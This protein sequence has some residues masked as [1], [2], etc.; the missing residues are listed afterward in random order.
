MP[1]LAKAYI[2]LVLSAGTIVLLYAASTWSPANL[3]QFTI[4]LGLAAL[5]SVLKVR[6]PRLESTISP[7][8]VFLLSGIAAL[9]LSQLVVISLVAALVQSLWASAKRPRLVQVGFSAAALILSSGLA[10]V[11]SHFIARATTGASP[12]VCI[13]LA[14]SFYFPINS[15]LV[16]IVI[17]LVE[18]KPLKQVCRNCYEWVFPYFLGG[19]AFVGLVCGVYAPSAAWK[20]AIVLLPAVVLA[21]VYFLNRA[22][23]AATTELA[24]RTCE[25]EDLVELHS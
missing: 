3:A 5:A 17:G 14:G 18:D 15:L 19:I 13:I 16:S 10:Y 1:R 20:G 23:R 24:P 6:I 8:F 21:Y 12:V 11:F 7:N 4:Y 9:P 25:E 22:A 2:A